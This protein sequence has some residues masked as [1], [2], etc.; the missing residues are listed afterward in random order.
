MAGGALTPGSTI[1]LRAETAC[2]TT[3]YVRH[4]FD[5]AVTSV[6]SSTSPALD[7]ADASW[8]VR[9]GPANP[10]CVSSESRNYP[11]D[12]LRHYDNTV[13]IAA[14]GGPNAFDATASWADDVSWAAGSPWT[15]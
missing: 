6:A 3:R 15:P 11:G 7:E 2:C 12:F 4:Q 13:Y 9:R 5:D 8:I 14:D 1:S 10:S